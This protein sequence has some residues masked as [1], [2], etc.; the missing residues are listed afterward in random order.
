M[1]KRLAIR[2]IT[3]NASNIN[4][5][6]N[7]FIIMRITTKINSFTNNIIITANDKACILV[8]IF[9]DDIVLKHLHDE[10]YS[11]ALEVYKNNIIDHLEDDFDCLEYYYKLLKELYPVYIEVQH[12][13]DWE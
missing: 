2:I 3:I 13:E 8:G 4:T 9:V 11:I 12:I 1:I 5:S 10:D 7:T 6:I